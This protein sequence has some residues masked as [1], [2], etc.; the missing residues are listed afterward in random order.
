[1]RGKATAGI[2]MGWIVIGLFS[3][4]LVIGLVAAAANIR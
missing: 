2:V 3:L 1:V 4:L